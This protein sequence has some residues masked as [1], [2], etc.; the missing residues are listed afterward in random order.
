MELHQK[1]YDEAAL[2]LKNFNNTLSRQI[3]VPPISFYRGDISHDRWWTSATVVFVNNFKFDPTLTDRIIELANSSPQ[4]RM[5]LMT[6]DPYPRDRMAGKM[7]RKR[8]SFEFVT[9]LHVDTTW[10]S[11]QPVVVFTREQ[12]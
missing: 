8:N 5:L 3:E 4:V 9:T 6:L 2:I 7:K 1:R 10:G 12:S 11:D